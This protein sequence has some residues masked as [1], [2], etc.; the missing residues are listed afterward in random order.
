MAPP[1]AP[2]IAPIVARSATI[3]AIVGATVGAIASRL[4][5][6]AT[7]AAAPCVPAPLARLRNKVWIGFE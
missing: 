7:F 3:L 5:T 2:T 6:I 1:I 4:Q